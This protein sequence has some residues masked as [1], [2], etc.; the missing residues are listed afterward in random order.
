MCKGV[1]DYAVLQMLLLA[2]VLS[3]DVPYL[4]FL[5][6]SLRYALVSFLAGQLS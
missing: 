5:L 6:I 3:G 1:F 4:N 2:N